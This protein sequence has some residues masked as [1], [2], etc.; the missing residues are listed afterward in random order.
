MSLKH[1]HSDET[2]APLSA[3]SD[4]VLIPPGAA[5][6]VSS[7][8][9][10]MLKDGTIP[11]DTEQQIEAAFDN[12]EAVLRAAGMT[13]SDV[14]KMTTFITDPRYRDAFRAVRAERVGNPPPSSTRIVVTS[15]SMPEMKVEI[16]IIAAKVP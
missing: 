4:A 9:I 11:E 2:P 5:I 3:H 14:V 6:L 13:M 16:E 12:V 8:Q 15:L 7:G 1:I 10:G